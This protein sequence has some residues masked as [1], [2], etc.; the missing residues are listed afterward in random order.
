LLIAFD[1]LLFYIVGGS[2]LVRRLLP[3][4]RRLRAQLRE[5]RRHF[6]GLLRRQRDVLSPEQQSRLRQTVADIEA[7]RRQPR[8]PEELE[9]LLT[10]L[11]Q[12][13]AQVVP[14]P[15]NAWIREHVEVIVVAVA[16]AFGIRA[17]FLQPFKIPTGSMQPTL[18]G[19][20]FIA[21]DEPSSAGRLRRFFDYL[22][23]SK[24]YVDIV[25]SQD[26]YIE[27]VA[28]AKPAIPFFPAT[29]LKIGG[30]TY[31]F[32]GDQRALQQQLRMYQTDD[33]GRLFYHKGDVLARGYLMLGDHLFV[34]R[35]HYSF[36]E[37]R[38]GD[39]TV[40]M[41]DGITNANGSPLGG[42]YYIKR[43]VGLPGDTLRIRNNQLYVKTKGSDDFRPV[44][45]T[46]NPA[47]ERIY[48]FKGGYAGHV[49]DNRG[50][51]LT[52]DDATFEI[53]PNRY[54]MMGDNTKNSLDSRFWGT[55]PRENL[56]GRPCAIWWP[57]SRRWG[58]ADQNLP[59][60][61]EGTPEFFK[62]LE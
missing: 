32:P 47:F 40:F 57:F 48:S 8:T 59:L 38:R 30:V 21:T 6:A 39:I 45:G 62:A 15:K 42:R 28:P 34:D 9:A 33:A 49:Q 17:M 22:H 11:E 1:L 29:V 61:A 14:R 3:R 52:A 10:R 44:S 2:A 46:D 27:S 13:D 56:V 20:H 4:R 51:Y 19:I 60:A 12:E 35:T 41:T 26:G 43:L 5:L 55:V 23:Y 37:P 53:P 16:L 50:V 31:R 7:A 24:R 58:G 36:A 18:Y 25:A 54:F